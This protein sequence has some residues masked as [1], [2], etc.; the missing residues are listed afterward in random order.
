MRICVKWSSAAD[1]K[2]GW[3]DGSGQSVGKPG[4]EALVVIAGRFTQ[5]LRVKRLIPDLTENSKF[6]KA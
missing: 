1:S 2:R 4:Y 6:R 5:F 3:L